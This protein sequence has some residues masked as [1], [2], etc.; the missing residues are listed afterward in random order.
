MSEPDVSDGNLEG[1]G[2]LGGDGTPPGP[3]HHRDHH[4]I[5]PSYVRH[6]LSASGNRQEGCKGRC[7]TFDVKHIII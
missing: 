5:L 6:H 2:V 3:P 4:P 7:G 1:G